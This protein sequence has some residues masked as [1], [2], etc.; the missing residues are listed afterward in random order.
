MPRE[1]PCAADVFAIRALTRPHRLA[2]HFPLCPPTAAQVLPNSSTGP[3][4]AMHCD[5][6]TRSAAPALRCIRAADRQVLAGFRSLPPADRVWL[7][8][9]LPKLQFPRLRSRVL[10]LRGGR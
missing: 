4:N 3:A 9:L 1:R 6:D 5:H 2:A 10:A 8:G 7:S